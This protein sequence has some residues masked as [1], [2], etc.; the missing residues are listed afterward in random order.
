MKM[1][2]ERLPIFVS[3]AR[4]EKGLS[5][6]VR[7]SHEKGCPRKCENRTKRVVPESADEV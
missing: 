3:E 2:G 4:D 1:G 7:K 5:P 6:K